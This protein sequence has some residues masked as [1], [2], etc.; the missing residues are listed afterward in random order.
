MRK[1][2][3]IIELSVKK[4]QLFIGRIIVNEKAEKLIINIKN[5]IFSRKNKNA[6]ENQ[7]LTSLLN[8]HIQKLEQINQSKNNYE[9]KEADIID[10]L[11]SL[12][13]QLQEKSNLLNI[14]NEFKIE[15][16]P[17]T[18]INKVS[19]FL[20][21][22]HKSL[23][24]IT[25]ERQ[26]QA[27][28]LAEEELQQQAI[29]LAEER[30]KQAEVEKQNAIKLELETIA[31]DYEIPTE[32]VETAEVTA[33]LNRLLALSPKNK[34]ELFIKIN[35]LTQQLKQSN[36]TTSLNARIASLKD[37]IKQDPLM[38]FIDKTNLMDVAVKYIIDSYKPNYKKYT[39]GNYLENLKKLSKDNASEITSNI[40]RLYEPL[41][42]ASFLKIASSYK[43][44]FD[45]YLANM[46][47]T[48]KNIEDRKQLFNDAEQASTDE[49]I[50][51]AKE[52]EGYVSKED[53][54][55]NNKNYDNKQLNAACAKV[56]IESAIIDYEYLSKRSLK[57]GWLSSTKNFKSTL[58]TADQ[59]HALL[60]LKQLETKLHE[61]VNKLLLI[62]ENPPPKDNKITLQLTKDIK[63]L[64][65]T[66]EDN[67]PK[68][69]SLFRAILSGF[70]AFF[71]A[72]FNRQ[73][74]AAAEQH[75][76]DVAEVYPNQTENISE[77]LDK[78][79]EY[80][81]NESFT[82]DEKQQLVSTLDDV[83]NTNPP[84]P[85]LNSIRKMG[86]NLKNPLSRSPKF[87]EQLN[88]IKTNAQVIN[89]KNPD[90]SNEK[91]NNNPP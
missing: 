63:D 9:K 33:L 19:V 79:S 42:R 4:T 22:A 62:N 78:L 57:S 23:Y 11:S 24:N 36:D 71:K 76:L 49:A 55:N 21:T 17:E 6:P 56:D 85:I 5:A 28:K 53:L 14:L 44:F 65:T 68:K 52:Q 74:P 90:D 34:D 73:R 45:P 31:K 48:K 37:T 35:Q 46:A 69:H 32:E 50:K 2:C 64:T 83:K 25:N 39:D 29:K 82:Q 43:N 15:N 40:D 86:E 61:A 20:K 60:E 10:I 18:Q 38:A 67:L 58:D 91:K 13:N 70:I 80:I 3:T 8:E 51:K 72:I 12:D 54:K 89:P 88:E 30:N 26:Q 81:K 87:K 47:A 16:L 75:E 77:T 59:K 1:I 41:R 7:T 66:P 84:K 27:V